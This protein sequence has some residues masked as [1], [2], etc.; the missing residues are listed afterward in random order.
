MELNFKLNY[1]RSVNGQQATTSSNPNFFARHREK[2][3]TKM[4]INND[5]PSC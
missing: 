2:E 1:V 3:V 5:W 4:T